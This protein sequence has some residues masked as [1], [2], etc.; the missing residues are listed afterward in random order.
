MIN[1]QFA[2]FSVFLNHLITA[3]ELFHWLTCIDVISVFIR[4]KIVL[5]TL[6]ISGFD[7]LISLNEGL[8]EKLS[9]G[10]LTVMYASCF[11]N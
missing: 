1:E 9:L 3:K 7:G 6:P 8:S 11:C 2:L 4:S 5:L 10:Y